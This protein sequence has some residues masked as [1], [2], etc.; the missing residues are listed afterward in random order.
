MEDIEIIMYY[1][2]GY[3]IDY[4]A[5]IYYKYVNKGERPIYLNG[6]IL[7]PAKLYTKAHCR[8]KVCEVIYKYLMQN[9]LQ[10][11]SNSAALPF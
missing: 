4:I 6:T 1:K 7:F 8:V 3:T 5:N 10:Q 11:T 2:K 9:D